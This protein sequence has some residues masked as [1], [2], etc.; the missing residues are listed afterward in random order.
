MEPA[1]G[2]DAT[3]RSYDAVA[4]QYAAKLRDELDGK[5]LDRALLCCLAEMSGSG[6]PVADVGCG[7]GHVAAWLAGHGTAAVGIDLSPGM[8][9]VGRRLFPGV[10]L[11]Q[12]DFLSLPAADGEFAGAAAMYSIIHLAPSE[13]PRA[14]AELHRVLRPGGP[15]LVA[16][17][18]GTE[19]RHVQ[20]F[21]GQQVDLD[22]RFCDPVAITDV[23]AAAGLAVESTLERSAY[24]HEVQTRRAYLLAT[25]QA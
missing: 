1:H 3:R 4:E 5:P 24:P 15:L 25:R 16:F 17:H 9:A 11:R 12:G 19:V 23:M 13:L 14:F 20:E 6:A 10:E 8:V 2:H 22:F 21:L 7:P 18:V